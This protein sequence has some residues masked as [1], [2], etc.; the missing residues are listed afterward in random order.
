[1]KRR[2]VKHGSNT[3]TVSLPAKWCK[4]FNIKNGDEIDVEEQGRS[5]LLKTEGTCNLLTKVINIDGLNQ[6]L[7]WRSFISAYREGYNE[8]ILKFS[9][10]GKTYDVSLS[11]LRIL[12]KRL[13]MRTMEIIHDVVSRC[14]GMEIIEQE[15]NFCIVKD[16]GETSQKEFENTLR[17][18]FLLLI[19]VAEE[20]LNGVKEKSESLEYS[21]VSIDV[22]I[23]RFS[24]FCMRVLN[25]I[26][27]KDSNKTNKLYAIIIILEMLG[28]DYKKIVINFSESKN[29]EIRP[30]LINLYEEINKL[31]NM[32]YEFFYKFDNKKAM[33]IYEKNEQINEYTKTINKLNE[34]EVRILG[35]LFKIRTEI[36]D[37]VYMKMDFEA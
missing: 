5:I 17:R 37:L 22:N 9:D 28:D 16:L 24:D 26:G 13:K 1:M 27:Y 36:A 3:L 31:L 7:I 21:V 14:I 33:D 19:S 20:S 10:I 29:K 30:K 12:E 32:F 34:L 23:D 35:L 11:S 6:E 8:I 15:K 18:V 25:K 2:I 4:R